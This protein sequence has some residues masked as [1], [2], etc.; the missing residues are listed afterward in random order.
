LIG[1]SCTVGLLGAAPSWAGNLAAVPMTMTPIYTNTAIGLGMID[2]ARRST[3]RA[4]GTSTDSG[5]GGGGSSRSRA[6][7]GPVSAA[8]ASFAVPN[9][10]AV[11]AQVRAAFLDNIRAHNSP[12][13]AASIAATFQRKPVRAAYLEAASPYGITD[14]DLRDVTAAYLTIAWMT[15]NKAPLP[16]RGQVQGLRRQVAEDLA[17]G[18]V[19]SDARARQITAEQMMYQIVSTIYARQEAEKAGDGAALQRMADQTSA[20]FHAQK[21][22]L[23]AVAL[24]DRGFS[25][26]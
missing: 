17:K 20:A 6:P 11:S 15:A 1:L 25:P 12:Q 26:R 10:P 3:E 22:N 4:Y 5:G 18:S 21:L 2:A 19:A 16:T 24:T 23:R 8:V 14:L 7:V 13:A 9:D